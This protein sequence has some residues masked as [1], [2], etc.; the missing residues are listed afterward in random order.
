[1]SGAERYAAMFAALA[2]RGEGALVPFAVLG[3]PDRATSLAL[4]RALADAG[5]DAVEV[6]VP[7]SDP[8]A[9]GPVIQAAATRALIAHTD[10]AGCWE[11]VAALRASHPQLPI[12]VLTYANLAL[13]GGLHRFYADASAA[14]VDSVL[15]AD[16]PM[17]EAAPF[18]AAAA[19][20]RVAFVAMAPPN[21]PPRVLDAVAQAAQGYTYVV[22]R[23]GVTGADASPRHRAAVIIAA[24]RERNAAPPLLGFGIAAPE[25]V[26][27]AIAMGAAG[28]ITGSAVV[29]RIAASGADPARALRD[30][31]A[32]VG[33][34]KAATRTATA[35]R[36]RH[37]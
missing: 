6:G 10:V 33:E 5:A 25:H 28:A 14:G 16:V 8:I 1:V 31:T 7:F 22:S 29:A 21:A 26:R 37:A 24:L 30:I 32:F 17:D 12:G 4:L 20:A 3:D 2:R 13:R 27:E 35:P 23:P 15:V 19:A 11:L 9:D 18:R 36:P 34:L